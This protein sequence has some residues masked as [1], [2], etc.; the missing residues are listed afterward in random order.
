M[1]ES[2][3]NSLTGK[4]SVLAI[5]TEITTGQITNRNAAWIS[6]K[7]VNLGVEVVLHETVA[8]D[9]GAIREALEHCAKHSQLL[10]ITGGLGPTTDD[11]TREVVSEWL[12]QPLEYQESAWQHIV[13]RLTEFGIP[14]AET[15]RRQCYFPTSSQILPNSEGTAAGFTAPFPASDNQRIWVLPGPPR[16]ISAIW[17]QGIENQIREMIPKLTPRELLTWQ[18]LGKSEAELGEITEAALLGSGLQTGYRAH[19]PFVEIKV[20]CAASILQEKMPWILKLENAIAPWTVATEE[21][22]LIRG[23]LAALKPFKTIRIFDSASGG[24]LSERLTSLLKDPDYS[25]LR[26]RICLISQ[27][28]NLSAPKLW[29]EGV[30]QQEP[31]D[32]FLTLALGGFTSDGCG[33]LGLRHG[34]GTH[35]EAMQLPYHK[36]ELLSRMRPYSVEMAFKR[37]AELLA[38]SL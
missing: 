33:V 17:E 2:S 24:I 8:D 11:F 1:V 38:K 14:V 27:W 34:K 10:F 25:E 30:L 18:C 12:K 26:S 3:I 21:N 9:R 23:F 36:I 35:Q 37:W 16:E 5:G 19:R 13:N 28:G 6:E 22:D 31:N 7:L 15:N 20:W 32:G 4:A 29:L